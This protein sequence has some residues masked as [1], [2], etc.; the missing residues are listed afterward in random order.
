MRLGFVLPHIGPLASPD[1]IVSVATRAEAVGY[2]SLWVTDRLLFPLNPRTPYPATPDGSL[3]DAYRYVIDPLTA[4]SLA[5]A[6]T[7]RIAL[8]TSVLDIPYYNPILLARSLAGLDIISNG[9][10]RVGLG[11]GWSIDE[12]EAVGAS[13]QARGRR[14]DEFL[15]VLKAVWGPDPVSFEGEFYRVAPSI[16]GAKPVQQP[17]PPLYMAAYAP[18]ALRRAAQQADGWN[19]AGVPLPG[20]VGWPRRYACHG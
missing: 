19:P 20:H 17:H 5:A 4:L 16:I 2:D 10:L 12:Y 7:Q 8:G 11:L 6:N 9:R 18:A 14:A 15:A 1:A 3:P 13:T